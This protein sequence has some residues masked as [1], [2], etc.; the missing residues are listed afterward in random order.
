[1]QVRYLLF[2]V[3]ILLNLLYL[4]LDCIHSV[5]RVIL[6]AIF[7]V[8]MNETSKT[9]KRNNKEIT[10]QTIAKKNAID[11]NWLQLLSNPKLMS[12]NN[13]EKV[14]ET[15]EKKVNYTGTFRRARKKKKHI[16]MPSSSVQKQL[17][18]LD[19]NTE[20]ENNLLENAEVKLNSSQPEE[21][22]QGTK[23]N[24]LTKFIAIDCEMVGIGYEGRD[25]MLARVSLVNKFGDCIYD[26]FVKPREEVVDYRTPVSGVR[27]EDLINAEEFSVV[28]REVAE[29]LKGRILVGH[30]IKNDLNVLFLSHPKRNIRDTSK[31]KPF[32]K[33]T[34]GSS[35]SL[36]VLAKEV[37][38]I[39]IQ[40][41]EHSSVEDAQAAM[42]LYCTVAKNWEQIMNEKRR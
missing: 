4:A 32:R 33:I 5:A 41:G 9:R 36:K 13:E 38:G 3:D 8:N 34:K 16:E 39:N 26:K 7:H 12:N 10:N 14:K 28:Q 37:L 19:I 24:N 27:R 15:V 35:P 30:S 18:T 29:I 25:H 17:K 6:V 11:A 40:S 23:K 31:Y 2:I 42:K 22:R 21:N 1:M 20:T